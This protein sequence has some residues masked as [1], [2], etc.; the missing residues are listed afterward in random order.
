MLKNF[1][2]TFLQTFF[3]ANS[4]WFT[5]EH[6]TYIIFLLISNHL[7]HKLFIKKTYSSNIFLILVTIKKFIDLK[8]KTKYTSSKKKKKKLN[9]KNY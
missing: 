5:Y 2:I 6:T 7:L 4:Y 8:S 9:N 1:F 3:V